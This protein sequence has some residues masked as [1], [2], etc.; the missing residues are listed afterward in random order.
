MFGGGGGGGACRSDSGKELS[1]R[2][3]EEVFGERAREWKQGDVGQ[4]EIKPGWRAGEDRRGQE[5]H[6]SS[7]AQRKDSRREWMGDG[8]GRQVKGRNG[9]GGGGW[10]FP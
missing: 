5:T 8:G 4:L 6:L 2:Q 3:W 1:G 7:E 10:R 9:G